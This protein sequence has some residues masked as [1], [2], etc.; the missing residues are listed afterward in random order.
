MHT[1]SR[2]EAEPGRFGHTLRV[3]KEQRAKYLEGH[4]KNPFTTSA[5][6]GRILSASQ[7]PWFTLRPPLG[8]GVLT[9]V[10][11]R[12]GKKRRKCVRAIRNGDYVYV[13]SLGGSTS[14]WLLNLQA[15]PRVMLRIRGGR[16]EG[17]A[18]EITDPAERRQAKQVYAG[19]INSVDRMEYR[20]H[21]PD[22][23][24]ADRIQKMHEKWFTDG[25]AVVIEL[26]S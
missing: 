19:T 14:A 23:P 3:T 11:R 5:T 26:S 24:T 13:V 2:G 15:N 10:G 22:R 16:F 21:R 20:M 17:A 9:T 12:T 7:L 4:R 8:F 18:R 6:G 1:R 25:T